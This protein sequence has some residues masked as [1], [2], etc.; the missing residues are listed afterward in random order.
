MKVD[1]I[2][3][4]IITAAYNEAKYSKHEYF[5]PEHI[6]YASLFFEEGKSIIENC[7]GNVEYIKEDLIKY[8]KD[9]MDLIE[10]GEPIETIGVGNIVAAAGQHVLSAEKD[11]INLGDIFVAMYDEEESFSSYFLKK[12]GIQRLD[13]LNYISHG[14]SEFDLEEIEEDI[15]EENNEKQSERPLNQYTIDLTER[16]KNGQ[17][18]PLIG[19]EE[20]LDRTIQVLSRRLKNNPIHVGEPGVGK[21][22]ITEGLAIMIAENKV[23]KF[24]QGSKVYSLDMGTLLAGTKYRGDFENRIK[25]VLKSLEKEEKAIVY[26]DEIHTIIGAGAVS[27]GSVDASN[28]LKPF[29]AKGNIKFI[30]STT[31]DEYKKVF[32]KDKALARRFQKIEVKEPSIEDAFNILEGLK[33]SYEKFHNVKYTEES[34]RAAVELSAKYITDRYLPDK[35]IDVMDEVGAYVKLHLKDEESSEIHAKDVEKIVASIAKIPEKTVSVDEATILKNLDKTIKKEIFG[36][37]KAVDSI[38][39]AIKKSRAG[40]NDENKAVSNLLFVGPTGVGKT[41]ICKQVSK[42]LNIPLIRFDMSEYQEKHTV[43][44]LIGAPPGYVGYEEGGLLTD[45]VRKNPYCVLLLDEI[46]KVHPDVLN[47]LLQLM[48]YATLTDSTGKKVDFR[49]VILI[50]TSNAGARSIGKPLMGFGGRTVGNE[51]IDKEIERFFSP[52]FRNRL[53]SIIVFNKMNEDMALLVAKKAI[54]EFEEKLKTKNIKIQ[55]TEEC[56]NWL[57]SKGLSLE[58][59]AREIIRIISQQIKPYFVD[60]VL[61]EDMDNE[62]TTVI[63]VKDNKVFIS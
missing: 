51:S 53:D 40:F 37:E 44:R 59:G 17:I 25:N 45:A 41:E 48:D 32:E 61:F 9:N 7:G 42:A 57:A 14:A 28:I 2:V 19:R 10:K 18:D 46:E 54:K 22:A 38:V 49:N 34:L 24:L 6:L 4:E 47:V 63:D 23:P 29:L 31:Y 5:T 3:N 13:I 21:T 20:V 27:G 52:E 56:Y 36:Q 15:Y 35:A 50:M 43:A 16:A 58:Y 8:F 30:G 12:Q 39:T 11:V 26:I 60:K 33:E 1:T 62:K 55:V